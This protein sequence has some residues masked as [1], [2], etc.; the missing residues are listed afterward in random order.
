MN[1]IDV[2]QDPALEDFCLLVLHVH[3]CDYVHLF[4]NEREISRIDDMTPG[5]WSC[6]RINP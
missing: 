4:D 5:L 6:E 1:L 2:F 3:S